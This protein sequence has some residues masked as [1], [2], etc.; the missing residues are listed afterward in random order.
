MMRKP[1]NLSGRVASVTFSVPV[2]SKSSG[3]TLKPMAVAIYAGETADVAADFIR[4]IVA[5]YEAH[6]AGWQSRQRPA[7]FAGTGRVR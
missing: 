6:R 5:S 2:R 7:A 3:W 4:T 1:A